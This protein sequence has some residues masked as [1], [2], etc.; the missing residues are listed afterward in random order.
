V[1][2]AGRLNEQKGHI[3]LLNA[4]SKVKKSVPNSQLVFLGEGK[5]EASLK[6]SAK[7]LG[8]HNNVHF[9]GFKRNPFK[10]IAQS[11]VF[12]M[13]SYYEGF[14]NALAEAMACKI[15]VISTDCQSGPREILAPDITKGTI[16][17]KNNRFGILL[18]NI[19]VYNK[20][21]VENMIFNSIKSLIVNEKYNNDVAKKSYD[22]VNDFDIGRIINVWLKLINTN[23]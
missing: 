8:I 5:L 3:H 14:P 9:L 17:S 6:E 13:T 11:K 16:E 20:D 22:R 1:I 15:P 10:Y 19:T 21:K 12:V 2:T 7:E 23:K 18:P 4:F